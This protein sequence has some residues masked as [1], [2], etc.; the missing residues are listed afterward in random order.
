MPVA[1][2]HR[3]SVGRL[4]DSGQDRQDDRAEDNEP[5]DHR[6]GDVKGVVLR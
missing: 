2:A 4:C 3:G 6:N 5:D 1:H